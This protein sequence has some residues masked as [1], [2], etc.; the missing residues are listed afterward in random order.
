MTTLLYLRELRKAR[1]DRRR[2]G[3]GTISLVVS[4][5]PVEVDDFM[6]LVLRLLPDS[7]VSLAK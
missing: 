3:A 4:F 5:T 7:P 2:P 1:V 6:A